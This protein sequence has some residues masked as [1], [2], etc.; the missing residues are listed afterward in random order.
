MTEANILVAEEQLMCP[1]CLEIL[2]DPVAIPCGHSS[3]MGCIKNCWDQTE[4]RHFY[5]CSLCRKTFVRRPVLRRNTILAEIAGEFKKRRLNPPPA[6][7]YAGP[8]D[9]PCDFCTGR[10]KASYLI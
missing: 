4:H 6:Q 10:N 2:K 9:V 3:C 5:S 1:V 8:G 7:S